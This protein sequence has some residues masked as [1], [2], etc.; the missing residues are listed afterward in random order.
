MVIAMSEDAQ[1]PDEKLAEQVAAGDEQALAD[2]FDRHRYRLRQMVR[3]RLDR[4]L[5][6]RLDP[7]DVLQEAFLDLV[8]ELPT[9]AQ[10]QK[11]PL[12]LWMR[13][14]TGQ[15]LM[16][17]HRRHLGTQM[18]DAARDIS[19]YRGGIPQA[20]SISLAAQLLGRFTSA[21]HAVIRAEVQLQLQ[22][23]LD[24]M[25]KVDREIIALRNFEELDNREASEVLGL[26]PEAARKRYVRALKRLQSELRRFP[27]LLDP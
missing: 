15:R 12:F 1:I 4:R 20:D 3:L 11:L 2:L 8:A 25:D 13:L 16:Q 18:R 10:K 9:F 22:E 17:I 23:A 5:Q 24:S 27:G 19:L 7:S 21:G 26:S 6:G 14:V